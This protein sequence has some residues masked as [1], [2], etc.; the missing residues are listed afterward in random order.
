MDDQSKILA[1]RSIDENVEHTTARQIIRYVMEC[2][3]WGIDTISPSNE[4]L[5]KKYGW[6]FETT[7]VAI[8]K[9]KKSQFITTTGRSK[10]RCFELNVGFLKGK[11]AELHQR[12]PINKNLLRD[13]GKDLGILDEA[14]LSANEMANDSANLSA[15][16]QDQENAYIEPLNEEIGGDNNNSINNNLGEKKFSQE[17][18]QELPE[19]YEYDYQEDSSGG[20]SKVI[21]DPSGKT[22]TKAQARK[23]L[24]PQKHPSFDFNTQL[25]TLS[26]SSFVPHRIIAFYWKQKGYRFENRYQMDQQYKRDIKAAN[27]IHEANYSPELIKEVANF[28][29][30]NY[31]DWT[32][33]TLLKKAPEFNKSKK[34][35]E[36]L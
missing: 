23:L 8:S 6:S 20:V 5:A 33:E 35:D 16:F 14:N 30:S 24:K 1:Y 2:E 12:K 19:G 13:I 18:K 25:S 17:I 36:F 15:N 31:D 9:A 22:L 29:K 34:M 28:C 27:I 3:I 26:S 7:K 4:Y 21:I 32:L 10:T 11:M